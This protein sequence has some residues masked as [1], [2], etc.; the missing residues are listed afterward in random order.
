L[1]SQAPAHKLQNEVCGS[2]QILNICT[3][4]LIACLSVFADEGISLSIISQRR[5]SA[6]FDRRI[7]NSALERRLSGG[8]T[9]TAHRD[10]VSIGQS[11]GSRLFAKFASLDPQ[12]LPESG[13]NL[14]PKNHRSSCC[15][16]GTGR[17]VPRILPGGC[18]FLADLAPPPDLDP[19]PDPH[20]DFEL[21]PYC[22]LIYNYVEVNK[23]AFFSCCPHGRWGMHR[24]G[25]GGLCIPPGYAPGY[26]YI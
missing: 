23:L 13:S 5:M 6:I 4:C 26:R 18:T 25:R 15:C 20:Q 17:G 8:K 7:A 19:E 16:A 1:G 3:Q 2:M 11:P 10:I 14:E 12:T 21:D 22:C 9:H 24:G